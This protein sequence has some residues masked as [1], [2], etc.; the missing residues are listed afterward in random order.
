M[1]RRNAG[2]VQ[3]VDSTRIVVR[4]DDGAENDTYKILKL[5]T[6]QSGVCINQKPIVS[7]GETIG[8]REVIADGPPTTG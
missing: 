6:F 4:R 1:L 3:F 5:Q 2:V 8:G 7:L